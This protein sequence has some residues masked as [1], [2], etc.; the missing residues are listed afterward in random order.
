MTAT[1]WMLLTLV[2]AALSGVGCGSDEAP[3]GQPTMGDAGDDRSMTGDAAGDRS[4]TNDGDPGSM[5]G[6]GAGDQGSS[7]G[8]TDAADAPP[9]PIG[10]F[11]P[12]DVVIGQPD[13]KSNAAP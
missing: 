3:P 8:T 1:G 12:A 13:F 10:R 9:T 7:D 2:G 4:M 6:D 11:L 5:M